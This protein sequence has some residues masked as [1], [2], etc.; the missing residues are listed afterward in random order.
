MTLVNA[1][2]FQIVIDGFSGDAAREKPDLLDAVELA[3][4]HR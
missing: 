4:L 2:S 1:P 3:V